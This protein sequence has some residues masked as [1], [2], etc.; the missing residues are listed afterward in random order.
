MFGEVF[1]LVFCDG[2]CKFN[3]E[4]FFFFSY[5]IVG[6]DFMRSRSYRV[7]FSIIGSNFFG[8]VDC[9]VSFIGGYDCWFFLLEVK[10]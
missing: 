5:Y 3:G 7:S 8:C 10:G 4:D 1:G 2:V 9:F 6:I